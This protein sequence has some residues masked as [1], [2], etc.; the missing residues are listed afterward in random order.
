M[1]AGAGQGV[2]DIAGDGD[3]VILDEHGVVQAET[4]VTAAAGAYSI[5]LHR[6]QARRGLARAGDAGGGAG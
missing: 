5:F 6:P 3:M 1:G 4:V 2:A